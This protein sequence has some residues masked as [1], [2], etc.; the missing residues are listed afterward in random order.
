MKI[1]DEYGRTVVAYR[2]WR[3]VNQK[4]YYSCI[5]IDHHLYEA[6]GSVKQ[7][8]HYNSCCKLKNGR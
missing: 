1:D 3:S 6:L 8:S 2:E 7:Q 4:Q 5:R